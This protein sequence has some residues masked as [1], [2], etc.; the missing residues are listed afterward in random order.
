MN[1]YEYEDMQQFLND[2]AL[3]SQARIAEILIAVHALACM[4]LGIFVVSGKISFTVAY[5]ASLI[6]TFFIICRIPTEISS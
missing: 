1:I 2:E 6:L 4:A 3:K 5:L